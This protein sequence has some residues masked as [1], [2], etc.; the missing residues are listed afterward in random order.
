MMSVP[1]II[2]ARNEE[3]HIGE[4]LEAL[5]RQRYALNPLMVLDAD[6]RPLSK[7]WSQRFAQETTYLPGEQPAILWGPYFFNGEINTLAGALFTVTS[8]HVSW[9]D[10]DKI[11][12]RTVRGG[13]TALRLRNSDLLDELLSLD[14]Y[15]PR[16]DLA[17]YETDRRHGANKK[18]VFH[19]EAWVRTSGFRTAGIIQ[20]V[21]KERRHPSRITDDSYAR[22]AP[23]GSRPYYSNIRK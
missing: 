7:N 4:T 18:V 2:A 8:A 23:A 21:I 1:V 10:R 5:A 20:K 22:E 14:N 11:D 19:P 16:E 3:K 13:N 9:A 12:P 15:W 6:S 17:I